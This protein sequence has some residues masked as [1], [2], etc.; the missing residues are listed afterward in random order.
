MPGNN[1]PAI[2]M[3]AVVKPTATICLAD[4]TWWY[5]DPY[6][7]MGGNKSYGRKLHRWSKLSYYLS[8]GYHAGGL[9]TPRHARQANIMF[10]DAHVDQMIPQATELGDTMWDRN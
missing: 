5:A 9:I 4:C 6:T 3:G 10:C 7:G 2:R 8:N 1:G